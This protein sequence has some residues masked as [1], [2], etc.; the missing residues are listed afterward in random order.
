MMLGY[1]KPDENRLNIWTYWENPPNEEMPAY[2]TLCF[3]TIKRK[4]QNAT[5]HLVCPENIM[6]YLPDLM[7]DLE[8]IQLN[9]HKKSSLPQKVDYI[10]IKLLHD[11]GG[12]WLDIDSILLHDITEKI[13]SLLKK[14]SFIGMQKNQKLLP[15]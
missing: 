12:L 11:Y 5:V 3:E 9:D 6:D 7:P 4:S 15:T 10:R 14:F 13:T 8:G 2:L 1:I